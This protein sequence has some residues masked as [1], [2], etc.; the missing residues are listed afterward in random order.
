MKC[1]SSFKILSESDG[2]I[3]PLVKAIG[4]TIDL[5]PCWSCASSIDPSEHTL[6]SEE[7]PSPL[8]AAAAATSAPS[9]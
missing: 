3:L 2:V 7:K 4:S 9:S 1:L 8:A 5:Y 6:D